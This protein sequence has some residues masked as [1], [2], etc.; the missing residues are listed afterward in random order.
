MFKL[1][2]FILIWFNYAYSKPTDTAKIDLKNHFSNLKQY[3]EKAP[4]KSIRLYALQYESVRLQ[5][6]YAD[7]KWYRFYPTP[8]SILRDQRQIEVYYLHTLCEREKDKKSCDQRDDL[9]KLKSTRKCDKLEYVSLP[10]IDFNKKTYTNSRGE[11]ISFDTGEVL[12]ST[13]N[14][15]TQIGKGE[16]QIGNPPAV[17]PQAAQPVT[18]G[19]PLQQ[20]VG[21]GV[22]QSNV[23]SRTI[24]MADASDDS[25]YSCDWSKSLPRKIVRGPGCS[26][27]GTRICTGYVTCGT[28]KAKV[29]RLATCSESLC[30]E[31]NAMACAKQPTYGSKNAGENDS[32]FTNS[33]NPTGGVGS[34][35]Q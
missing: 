18:L 35:S 28:K 26:S 23:A 22:T 1:F 12:K 15:P 33:R 8:D 34:G 21:S 3:G 17:L 4:L 6:E 16:Q 25:D 10:V 7:Q 20:N 27:A 30:G 5:T 13:P 32:Q 9:C 11:V 2:I 19:S 31:G 14:N 24:S 29:D